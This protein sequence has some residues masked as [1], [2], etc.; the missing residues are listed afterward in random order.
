MIIL[1]CSTGTLEFVFK[2]N[3]LLL[4]KQNTDLW[5]IYFNSIENYYYNFY[6]PADSTKE[7]FK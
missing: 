3:F 1:S 6:N 2:Q 5:K 4:I 7:N